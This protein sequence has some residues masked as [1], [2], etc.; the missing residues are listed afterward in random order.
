M[1]IWPLLKKWYPA[2]NHSP[3]NRL[4]LNLRKRDKTIKVS[5]RNKRMQAG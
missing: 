5:V 1:G 2:A 4:A 3:L